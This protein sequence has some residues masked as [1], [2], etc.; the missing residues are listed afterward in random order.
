MS[1]HEN[2]QHDDADEPRELSEEELENVA[3]GKGSIQYDT[4]DLHP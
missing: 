4:G 1:D 2:E 3:G